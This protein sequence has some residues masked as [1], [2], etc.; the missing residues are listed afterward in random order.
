MAKSW[1]DVTPSDREW[2]L[3]LRLDR[4]NITVAILGALFIVYKIWHWS[5]R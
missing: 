3:K 4:L 1:K 2:E 5:G